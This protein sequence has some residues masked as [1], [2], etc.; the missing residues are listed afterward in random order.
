MTEGEWLSSKDPDS[1]LRFLRSDG[2]DG[3]GRFFAS[4]RKL[5]LFAAECVRI[6]YH[7]TVET[8]PELP[9][10]GWTTEEWAGQWT[11]DKPVPKTPT[12]SERAALLR[13][14]FGN[15]FRPFLA[16][17]KDPEGCYYANKCEHACDTLASWLAWNDGVVT[18][19]AHVIYEERDFESMPILA[20]SLEEA[21]C[22]NEEILNHCRG[23]EFC[24]DRTWA[25]RPLGCPHVRGCWVL[26]L[27]LGKE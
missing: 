9:P 2:D 13:D 25:T 22:D 18:K 24:D 26:D 20:D 15:P 14:I 7:D 19:V 6:A 12:M 21:G 5:R 1:M 10:D 8:N 27:L 4:D 11:S 16:R 3:M 23:L 17:C